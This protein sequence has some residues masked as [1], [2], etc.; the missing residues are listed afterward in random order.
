LA[1]FQICLIDWDLL[2]WG[3]PA[4]DVAYFIVYLRTHLCPSRIGSAVAAFLT[5]YLSLAR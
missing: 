4:F 2:A 5:G 1:A 3:D